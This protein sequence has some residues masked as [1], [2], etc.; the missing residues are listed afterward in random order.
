MLE[1]LGKVFFKPVLRR[2]HTVSAQILLAEPM[3]V[4]IVVLLFVRKAVI[5]LGE[6][7]G[8]EIGSSCYFPLI[9]AIFLIKLT[10]K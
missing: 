9:F 2:K 7:R 8:S 4:N 1:I 3:I 10:L 6:L 5:R